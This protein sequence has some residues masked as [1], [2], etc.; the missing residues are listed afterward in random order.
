MGSR[1][2]EGRGGEGKVACDGGRERWYGVEGVLARFSVR[3]PCFRLT[4]DE[5]YG[6]FCGFGKA[7][8]LGWSFCL[9]GGSKIK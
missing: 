9:L 1:G 3:Y 2:L 6:W 8:C 5:L 7:W 4:V